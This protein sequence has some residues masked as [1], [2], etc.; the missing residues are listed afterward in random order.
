[1]V[2]LIHGPGEPTGS[3]TTPSLVFA[4]CEMEKALDGLS[5]GAF[6]Y[7]GQS[8]ASRSTRRPGSTSRRGGT[9]A[10]DAQTALIP[11]KATDPGGTSADTVT[12]S[13]EIK[14]SHPG[15]AD[16]C[17]GMTDSTRETRSA[18]RNSLLAVLLVAPFMAQA[19]ATIANVA[20]P[21]LHADLGASGAALELV[22]GGYLIAFAVVLITGA[23]LGQTHG[24]RR[25]FV[26]GLAAF[27]LASLA[28]G[29]AP[30]PAVL[31]VARVVQ[32]AA[33]ALMFPQTLTGIQLSFDGPA[34]VRAIS[35]YAVALSVGAVAGQIL[36]GVLI[37]ANLAGSHWRAIFLI[38]VPIAA[39]TIA[40]ARR[41]LPSDPPR[42]SRSVDVAGV[43]AL[44]V[45]CLLVVLPLVLGRVE[46][47][48]LWTWLCLA[49]SGPAIA[50]FV[51]VQRRVAA[52]G[53]APLVNVG[54]LARPAVGWA[55]AALLV[56]TATYYALLFTLAQYLQ[57]GLGRSALVS[58]LTVV[59]WVAA[60]GLAGQLVQRLP[61][62]LAPAV[63]AAGCLALTA[64]YAAVSATL[65]A[66]AH[67]EA[68]LLALLA[69]GGLG[70]GINFSAILAHLTTAVPPGYAPDISGV[71]ST[72]AVIG[73]AIGVACFGTLYLSLAHAGEA[74]A[75]R[76]FAVTTASFAA[77]A[78]VAAV[79]ARRATRR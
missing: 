72:T 18:G 30:D 32:G 56:A 35:L 12:G 50:V 13:L 27:G 22:I 29:L 70:L 60:F 62:R 63:P 41:Y 9:S 54:V 49:A 28:C 66:G 36:G 34:R 37:S 71:T 5:W 79:A 58:G 73:G 11:I 69:A 20:T 76:A 53:G 14:P 51:L 57:E 23:R 39:I 1:V 67:P 4:D 10:P 75:T 17:T 77:A 19:D 74:D 43:A 7:G 48:P 31:V 52:R 65:F 16:R 3:G 42:A 55:L 8:S 24:Y 44:S 25:L 59:P 64:A 47:W 40:W 45:S 15:L 21:S 38:N 6:L 2:N 61:A 46:G 26:V 78:G 68:L 33:A